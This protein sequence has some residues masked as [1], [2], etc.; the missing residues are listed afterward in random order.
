LTVVAPERRPIELVP[1]IAAPAAMVNIYVG[2][3]GFFTAA[4]MIAG[5]L[6]LERRPVLAGILFG[7][8]TIKPQLESSL[9]S[10]W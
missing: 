10:F 4:L 3:N 2:Q 5:L 8:R 9:W 7:L 6:S 1:L